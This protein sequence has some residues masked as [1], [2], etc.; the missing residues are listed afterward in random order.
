MGK[1]KPSFWCGVMLALAGAARGQGPVRQESP[2]QPPAPAR[3]LRLAPPATPPG[4][5]P[6]YVQVNTG[7][8]GMNIVGEAAN[9]PSMTVDP[10]APNRIAVGWRQFDS[11]SSNFRQAGR[12]YSVDGV[13]LSATF[14][15]TVT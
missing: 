1:L 14:H 15:V 2:G 13:P 10:T 5:T 9:E 4:D 6:G 3:R 12:A 7:P 11:I 8:G